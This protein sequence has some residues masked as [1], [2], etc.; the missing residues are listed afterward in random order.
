MINRCVL[1]LALAAFTAVAAGH[2]HAQSAVSYRLNGGFGVSGLP[3]PVIDATNSSNGMALT[4][5]RSLTFRG[6]AITAGASISPLAARLQASAF[7]PL[8]AP[9][10]PTQGGFLAGSGGVTASA[11]L[12]ET[13]TINAPNLAGTR[14]TFTARF[15]V[16]GS[17]ASGQALG[18]GGGSGFGQLSASV[19]GGTVP[20]SSRSFT[21]S[22]ISSVE[23]FSIPFTYGTPLTLRLDITVGANVNLVEPFFFPQAFGLA[24]FGNTFAWAGLD[25]V[26]DA[27]G[28][29]VNAFSIVA[30]SGLD[31]TQPV[32][33]PPAI[34]A[35]SSVAAL[36]L[37]GVL[38]A[39]R[40]RR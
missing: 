9:N 25:A 38:A 32:P 14:G 28:N 17:T 30:P 35:P 20:N 33:L 11:S 13:L 1:P 39:R 40:R 12:S 6:Y 16:S 23:A 24:D 8:T 36:A 2:A 27:A 22:T 19:A 34:P 10:D 4:D 7:A 26:R 15:R 18:A 5:T 37:G 3:S 21:G 29:S 31:L